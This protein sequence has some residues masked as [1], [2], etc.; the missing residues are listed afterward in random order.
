[1]SDADPIV[2][3]V[4]GSTYA[5]LP[6]DGVPHVVTSDTN[7]PVEGPCR[8]TDCRVAERETVIRQAI[9]RY[10]RRMADE[11]RWLEGDGE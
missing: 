8:C 7:A 4:N 6:S 10:N 2:L 1:M 3:A 5:P 9:D 11:K